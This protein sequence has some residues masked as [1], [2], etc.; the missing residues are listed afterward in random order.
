M[1]SQEPRMNP[2]QMDAFAEQYI[3]IPPSASEAGKKILN[4]FR[5][6]FSPLPV[7][8]KIFLLDKMKQYVLHEARGLRL[9]SFCGSGGK[10]E[11]V[12]DTVGKANSAL[13]Q[14]L[15]SAVLLLDEG[16]NLVETKAIL[17]ETTDHKL[18]KLITPEQNRRYYAVIGSYNNASLDE[19]KAFN[20]AVLFNEGTLKRMTLSYRSR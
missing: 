11:D 8:S 17:K 7:E 4:V 3:S 9:M 12:D 13:R 19:R 20:D 18:I 6:Q 1:I 10:R 2:K 16:R 14:F 5:K 15:L